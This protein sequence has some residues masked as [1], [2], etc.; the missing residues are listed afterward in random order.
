MTEKS[1]A[2]KLCIVTGILAGGLCFVPQLGWAAAAALDAPPAAAPSENPLTAGFCRRISDP[3]TKARCWTDFAKAQNDPAVCSEIRDV[4]AQDRCV[5]GLARQKN[6]IVVCDRID[7]QKER[8]RCYLGMAVL[9]DDDSICD[10]RIHDPRLKAS[11]ERKLLQKREQELKR[12][13]RDKPESSSDTFH[14][15][16]KRGK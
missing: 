16:G 6:N 5:K 15:S 10:R 14:G 8:E 7:S 9:N 11:C 12:N 13:R 4:P 1:I 2:R 3:D